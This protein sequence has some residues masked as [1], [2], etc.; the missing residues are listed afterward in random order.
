MSFTFEN[1]TA[2][3]ERL[4]VLIRRD[5]R[6]FDGTVSARWVEARPSGQRWSFPIHAESEKRAISSL[7]HGVLERKV[8]VSFQLSRR[9]VG[10]IA[11]ELATVKAA[12]GVALTHDEWLEVIREGVF[13]FETAGG[14]ILEFIPDL[15]AAYKD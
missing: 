3:D 1:E 11:D 9:E 13:V 6:T 14:K 10:P 7:H 5:L 4:G 8:N 15:S 2:L 12:E